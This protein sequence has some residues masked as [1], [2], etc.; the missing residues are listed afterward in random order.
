MDWDKLELFTLQDLLLAEE[1]TILQSIDGVNGIGICY[2]MKMNVEKINGNLKVTIPNTDMINKTRPENVEYFN[3]LSSMVTNGARLAS[4]I[5]SSIV[6]AKTAFNKGALFTR[7][8]GLNLRRK[9]V[10]C[11]EQSIL[12][13]WN[14]KASD[15]RLEITGKF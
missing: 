1:E 10:K 3:C 2:R 8:L 6:M 14:L 5:K 9:L 15:S 12:W 11:S 7:K 4:E 13:R